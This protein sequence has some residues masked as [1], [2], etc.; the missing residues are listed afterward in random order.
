MSQK[1]SFN[2]QEWILVGDLNICEYS[3]QQIQIVND[4]DMKIKGAILCNE[5]NSE[6]CN[7]VPAFPSFCNIE[8]K[9]CISGLRE[10]TESFNELQTIS[11][12][13]KKDQAS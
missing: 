10:N 2:P 3:K 6:A 13:K 9:I 4:L 7:Q 11:N 1:M 8:T 5:S 12:E